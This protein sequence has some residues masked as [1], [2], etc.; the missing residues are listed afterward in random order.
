MRGQRPLERKPL[1]GY[2]VTTAERVGLGNLP[3]G[4]DPQGVRLTGAV[5]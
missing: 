3:A 2:G 4:P 1:K 5:S